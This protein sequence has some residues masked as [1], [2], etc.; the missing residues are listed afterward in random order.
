MT[1]CL[2]WRSLV[3]LSTSSWIKGEWSVRL[4][5]GL[6]LCFGE[7]RAK[8]KSKAFGLSVNLPP[9]RQ[10][11]SQALDSDRKNE[12][13]DRSDKITLL[14]RVDSLCL[15]NRMKSSVIGE[16]F[17]LEPL[18]LHIKRRQ[19]RWFW[20][21]I[22]MPYGYL[23]GV[24]FPACPAGRRTQGRAGLG[25]EITSLGWLG[26]NSV[27]PQ[28]SWKR[29]PGKERSEF[30]CLDWPNPWPWTWMYRRGRINERMLH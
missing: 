1:C 15:C 7:E 5:D 13:A 28:M 21:V 4:T 10:L 29:R 26:N 16:T 6:G 11:W 24:V 27:F 8:H 19:L 30:L 20:H 9:H 14:W 17:G 2:K 22:W 12:I 25:G 18:L 23:L 3:T